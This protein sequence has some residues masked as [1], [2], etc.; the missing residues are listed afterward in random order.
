MNKQK[1]CKPRF[2]KEIKQIRIGW[3]NIA[4]SSSLLKTK[5]K[6]KILIYKTVIISK[7]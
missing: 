1:R 4:Y 7:D 5:N 3:P 2:P 6:Q